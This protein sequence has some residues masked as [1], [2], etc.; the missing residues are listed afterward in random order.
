[1]QADVSTAYG[2]AAGAWAH[3]FTRSAR[4][5]PLRG[6]EPVLRQRLQGVQPV[7]ITIRASDD[8]RLITEAWQARNMRT[9]AEYQIRAITPGEKRDHIDIL[10]E[11]GVSQ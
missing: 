2:I 6:S 11:S 1:M 3:Q 4:V 9:G 8:A 7:V 10:A 5:R